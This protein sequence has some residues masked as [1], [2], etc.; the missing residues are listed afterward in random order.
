MK[1]IASFLLLIVLTLLLGSNDV[2]FDEP[3]KERKSCKYDP[4]DVCIYYSEL[5]L[6][7]K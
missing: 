2:A 1:K 5:L 3:G 7:H 4:S 6:N